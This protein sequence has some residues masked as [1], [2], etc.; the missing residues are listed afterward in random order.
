MDISLPSHPLPLTS[1]D[2][3][4]SSFLIPDVDDVRRRDFVMM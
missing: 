3:L 1:A 4:F 2:S